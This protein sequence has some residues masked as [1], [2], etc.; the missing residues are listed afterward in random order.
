MSDFPPYK[1]N[2]EAITR[3]IQNKIAEIPGLGGKRVLLEN[4]SIKATFPVC[5]LSN[6]QA[7]PKYFKAAYDLSITVEIWANSYYE[8]QALYDQVAQKLAESNFVE[9]AMTP[10]GK[11]PIIEKQRYGS[12]F[13]VGWNAID[14]TFFVNRS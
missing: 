13:E 1:M 2:R 14:N 8:A 6:F 4:P 11:D 9:V 7:R 5:V 3:L 10:Q 12:T